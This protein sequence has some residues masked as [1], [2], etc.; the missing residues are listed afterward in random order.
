MWNIS[1]P[2]FVNKIDL[3]SPFELVD[4]TPVALKAFHKYLFNCHSLGLPFATVIITS[5][6]GEIGC[7]DG[8]I[9]LIEHYKEQGLKLCTIVTGYAMSAGAF[10]FLMGA[11]SYRFMGKTATLMLHNYQI[12]ATDRLSAVKGYADFCEKMNVRL[13]ELVSKN[14]KKNKNWLS[15]IMA[16]NKEDDL[17]L[18]AQEAEAMGLC[19]IGIPNLNLDVFSTFSITY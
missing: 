2:N 16:N 13:N 12:G 1:Q 15:K 8:F 10:V 5:F 19:K 17:F 9:S 14:L 7:L 3:P 18:S 4:F 11:D 6:G